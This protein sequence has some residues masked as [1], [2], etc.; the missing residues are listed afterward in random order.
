ME[1]FATLIGDL[2][3]SKRH[4]DRGAVQAYLAAT[5][6]RANRRLRPLQ[7]LEVTVGDEFQGAF[8]SVTEAV[9]ASLV[10]RLELLTGEQAIDSRYGLGH[11]FATVFD[12]QR[13]PTSQ[14]GPAWWSARAAIERTKTRA[15]SAR[16]SSPRTGFGFWEAPPGSPDR[17]YASA[18]EAFL[19]TRDATVARMSARQRRLLLGVLHG[20]SQTELADAEGIT[21]SAVSQSLQRSGAYAVAAGLDVL[22]GP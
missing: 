19:F 20:R 21:Q 11:G 2:V 13:T 8:A 5:L 18:V 16:T 9:W 14:D 6:K 17:A 10:I 7:P 4:A 3:A 15:K 1:P 22:E 12:A